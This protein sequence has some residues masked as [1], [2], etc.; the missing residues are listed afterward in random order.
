MLKPFPE[1]FSLSV[2]DVKAFL[3]K[4][5]IQF[6]YTSSWSTETISVTTVESW[7]VKNGKEI[8]HLEYKCVKYWMIEKPWVINFYSRAKMFSSCNKNNERNQNLFSVD[9]LFF[10]K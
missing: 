6:S 2:H 3:H 4:L 5:I 1:I 7:S 8:L 10:R 9:H